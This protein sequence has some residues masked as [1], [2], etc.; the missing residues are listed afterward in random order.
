MNDEPK[1]LLTA[2]P[3][4][5]VGSTVSCTDPAGASPRRRP[6]PAPHGVAVMPCLAALERA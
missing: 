6:L 5:T 1:H 4:V 2:G 3:P